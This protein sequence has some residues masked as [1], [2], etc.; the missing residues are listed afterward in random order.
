MTGQPYAAGLSLI[1]AG[2]EPSAVFARAFGECCEGC[3]APVAHD[4]HR[5]KR[6]A[7]RIQE[8]K[9][10]RKGLAAWGGFKRESPGRKGEQTCRRKNKR[11]WLRL[12]QSGR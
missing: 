3:Y 4:Q 5:P 11:H 7:D 2:N 12:R 6:S 10:V 9:I 1:L 8:K